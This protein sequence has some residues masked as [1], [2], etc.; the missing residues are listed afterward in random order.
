MENVKK[1][2]GYAIFTD[3][4]IDFIKANTVEIQALFL[5]AENLNL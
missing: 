3:E 1:E 5:L 4:V 2:N